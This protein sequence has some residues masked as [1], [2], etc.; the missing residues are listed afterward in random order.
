MRWRDSQLNDGEDKIINLTH[1]VKKG[2]WCQGVP[3]LAW[4]TLALLESIH[5]ENNLELL[6]GNVANGLDAKK[7]M[8]KAWSHMVKF[9]GPRN[10]QKN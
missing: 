6:Q 3:S 4:F 1:V 5:W 10:K 9:H 7:F 8:H 2:L